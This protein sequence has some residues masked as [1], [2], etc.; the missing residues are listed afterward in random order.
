MLQ[1]GIDRVHHVLTAIDACRNLFIPARQEFRGHH[2]VLAACHIPQR[3]SH[4]LLRRAQLVGNR[5]VEEVHAEVERATYNLACRCLADGP[6]M[7][8]DGRVAESHATQ[9]DARYPQF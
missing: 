8:T 6:R 3:T 7:L 2:H 5:R 9:T 4:I 1:T